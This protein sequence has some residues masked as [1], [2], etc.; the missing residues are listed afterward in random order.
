MLFQ[1]SVCVGAKLV[2][3]VFTGFIFDFRT[4]QAVHV[5]PP[6]GLPPVVNWAV[7]EE[8]ESKSPR[9]SSKVEFYWTSKSGWATNDQFDAHHLGGRPSSGGRLL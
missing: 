5:A 8:R 2:P 7:G 6:P 1:S 3:Q 9:P 4:Q